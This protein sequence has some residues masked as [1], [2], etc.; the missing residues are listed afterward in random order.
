MGPENNLYS[1]WRTGSVARLED[2]RSI[3]PAG[4]G[5]LSPRHVNGL[6]EMQWVF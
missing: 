3:S 2:L 6:S 5:K 1:E 4:E